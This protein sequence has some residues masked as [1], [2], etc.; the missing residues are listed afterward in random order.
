MVLVAP[1]ENNT[2][3]NN[4]VYVM[5][6]ID[7]NEIIIPPHFKESL[8]KTWKVSKCYDYYKKH[9]EFDREIFLN[10]EYVLED[11]YVAY[12]IAKMLGIES[13]VVIYPLRQNESEVKEAI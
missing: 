4:S 10:E 3:N 7:I 5:L 11:G 2:G 1:T 13:V 9:G 12:L 8:P 6:H